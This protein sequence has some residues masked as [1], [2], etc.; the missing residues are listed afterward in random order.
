[1][2]Q[3][4]QNRLNRVFHKLAQI[5]NN[6]NISITGSI[7]WKQKNPATKCYPSE[8]WFWDSNHL[9]LMLC[10]LSHWGTSYLGDLI[11]A[12]GV[13]VLTKWSKSKIEEVQEQKTIL[14]YPK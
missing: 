4:I 14:G 11:S 3:L 1:M 7:T 9:D 8:H 13:L 6:G 5:G 10:F 12:Y 2:E